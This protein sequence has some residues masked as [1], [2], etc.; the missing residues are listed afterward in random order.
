MYRF[1]ERSVRLQLSE[2]VPENEEKKEGKKGVT[3]DDG[4][5]EAKEKMIDDLLDEIFKKR[6]PSF[7]IMMLTDHKKLVEGLFDVK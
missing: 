3:I 6:A 5:Q 4:G 1:F 7:L 2:K